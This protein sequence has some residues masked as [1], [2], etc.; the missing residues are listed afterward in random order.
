MMVKV[1]SQLPP[2]PLTGLYKYFA[3]EDTTDS[4]GETSLTAVG[5]PTLVAAKVSS[6][7]GYVGASSQSH[8]VTINTAALG[9][10][11][12]FSLTF[13]LKRSGEALGRSP[14]SMG[15]T[16]SSP[17]FMAKDDATVFNL[18][19]NGAYRSGVAPL[20]TDTWRHHVVTFNGIN[21]WKVYL[22]GVDT[23]TSKS[24]VSSAKTD[25][26]LRISNGYGGYWTGMIDEVGLWARELTPTEISNLYNSGVG[27][28]YHL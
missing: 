17:F 19:I 4:L 1:G 11:P 21:Q 18:Y 23:N 9:A 14:I 3:L 26:L 16:T 12:G 28:T 27:N 20:P 22:D 5:T 2:F 25:D 24:V 8:T 13:W 15:I 7:Y 6:G 10:Q